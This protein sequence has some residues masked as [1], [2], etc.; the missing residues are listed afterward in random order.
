MNSRTE[1][2][3]FERSIGVNHESCRHLH[4]LA[5][6]RSS[7]GVPDHGEQLTIGHRVI[8]FS[9]CIDECEGASSRSLTGNL[10]INTHLAVLAK[11][12]Q[13]YSLTQYLC[14]CFWQS[15]IIV[16]SYFLHTHE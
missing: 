9:D 14:I 13:A 4:L 12:K 5:V 2:L 15:G 11:G 7:Q 1:H 8:G 3:K 6:A 16:K 10:G